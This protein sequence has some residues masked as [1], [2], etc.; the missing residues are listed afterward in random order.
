MSSPSTEANPLSHQPKVHCYGNSAAFCAE[1]LTATQSK[2]ALPI[3][4]LD[5]APITVAAQGKKVHWEHKITIQ[6]NESE[7]ISV[8]ALLL[9]YIN[10]I[11]L[12]RPGKGIEFE[13]QA[14]NVFVKASAGKGRI[15][16]LPLSIGG[17]FKLSCLIL[18]QLQS[19]LALDQ[20]LLLAAIRGAALLHK[21]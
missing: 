18:S 5:V 12:K 21:P 19:F 1:C 13:R 10:R 8:A 6:L 17:C 15:Y 7:L 14:G 3:I 9:G 16:P 11:H 4:N 2:K 20:G